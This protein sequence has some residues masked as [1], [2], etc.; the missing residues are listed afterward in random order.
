MDLVLLSILIIMFLYITA[1]LLLLNE[2]AG[3]INNISNSLNYDLKECEKKL[4]NLES[5]AQ[6]AKEAEDYFTNPENFKQC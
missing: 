2:K 3:L 1:L 4:E 5:E 6:Y